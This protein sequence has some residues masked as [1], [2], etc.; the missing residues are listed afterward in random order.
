MI[1]YD[2]EGLLRLKNVITRLSKTRD[3]I[4]LLE[5]TKNSLRQELEELKGSLVSKKEQQDKIIAEVIAH[6]A[7]QETIV[8]NLT[9]STKSLQ[10]SLA[11][12]MGSVRRKKADSKV[13][14]LRGLSSLK[15]RLPYPVT[16]RILQGY[17]KQKHKEFSDVLLIKGVEF[18]VDSGRSVKA[19]ASGKV[20]FSDSLPGYGTMIIVDHGQRFYTLYGKLANP[21]VSVGKVV[22]AGEDIASISDATTDSAQ[23][24]FYF[25][26]RHKG[27][28]VNPEPFFSKTASF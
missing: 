12:I 20:I 24:N 5:K 9:K 27:I 21:K 10:K 2:R 4:S 22:E 1:R 25:E 19:I 18:R 8:S 11:Q 15:G 23:G 13:E 28:A 7:K 17:G 16:G 3:E 6:K 14:T 26:L